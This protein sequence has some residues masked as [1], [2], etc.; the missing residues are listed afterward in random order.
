MIRQATK[1]DKTQVIE[2][3]KAFRAESPISAL[4]AEDDPEYW[5]AMLTSI[6]AGRGAVFIEDGKGLLLSMVY[7]S[8]WSGKVFGLHELAWYVYPQHR[9]GTTGYRLVRAYVDF[10]K[11][12]KD[13]GRIAYFTLSK[14]VSS[15][16]MKYEKLGFKKVDENWLQ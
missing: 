13:S 15:P 16:A 9:G 11:G 10:A 3:M 12:L 6:F 5:D 7:P 1:Y 14:M 2:M 4:Y 8:I